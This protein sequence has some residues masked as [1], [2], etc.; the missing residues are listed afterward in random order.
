MALWSG[1]KKKEN[2]EDAPLD[3]RRR[4]G[5]GKAAG[6]PNA[7][8]RTREAFAELNAGGQEVEREAGVGGAEFTRGDVDALLGEKIKTKNKFD[9]KVMLVDSWWGWGEKDGCF[10]HLSLLGGRFVVVMTG[11]MRAD[12]RLRQEAEGLPQMVRRAR[13]L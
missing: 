5:M 1:E 8:A 3:K 7:G 2:Q 4:I 9:Y 10:L 6:A 11:Q 12:G 13:F